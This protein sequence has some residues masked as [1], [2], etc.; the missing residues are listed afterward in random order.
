MLNST[1]TNYFNINNLAFL[2]KK[3]PYKKQEQLAQ[4]AR[5]E[6]R[7]YFIRGGL[8]TDFTITSNIDYKNEP[9]LQN[10]FSFINTWNFSAL[11]KDL[12]DNNY[13]HVG[14]NTISINEFENEALRI[15]H[16]FHNYDLCTVEQVEISQEDFINMLKC[17]LQENCKKYPENSLEYQ[18][19]YINLLNKIRK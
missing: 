15:F 14:D 1:Q 12:T 10:T 16:V 11:C 3:S 6:E 8:P 9:S 19:Q 7:D 13:F 18:K 5:T 2:S 4:I 17:A